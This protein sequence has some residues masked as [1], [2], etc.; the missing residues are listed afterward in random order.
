MTYV[1]SNETMN[2]IIRWTGGKEVF[3]RRLRRVQCLLPLLDT[4]PL[5]NTSMMVRVDIIIY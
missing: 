3:A 2:G 5:L 1:W 4:V